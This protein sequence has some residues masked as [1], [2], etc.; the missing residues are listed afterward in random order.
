MIRPHR[1]RSI[2]SGFAL[3]LLTFSEVFAASAAMTVPQLA[4]YQGAD[5]EKILIEGAKEEGQLTSTI[6]IPG[7]EPSPRSS[8]RSIRSSKFLSFAPTAGT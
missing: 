1:A 2:L 7:F 6:R 3:Y 4:L 5:R 8:R